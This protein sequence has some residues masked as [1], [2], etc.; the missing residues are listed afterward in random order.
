MAAILGLLQLKP[1]SYAVAA[2]EAIH[3]TALAS[4]GYHTDRRRRVVHNSS[5]GTRDDIWAVYAAVMESAAPTAAL[6]FAASGF[7]A[8]FP[9]ESVRNVFAASHACVDAVTASFA[10]MYVAVD[11]VHWKTCG[12][13]VAMVAEAEVG[14]GAELFEL[15]GLAGLAE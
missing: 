10:D 12:L 5:S 4:T 11:C 3:D 14:A 1:V 7:A 9:P 15:T 6:A 8:S 2:V 13:V